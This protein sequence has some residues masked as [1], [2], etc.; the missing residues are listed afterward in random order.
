MKYYQNNLITGLKIA[1]WTRVGIIALS[2]FITIYILITS[3]KRYTAAIE[4]TYVFSSNGAAIEVN[5]KK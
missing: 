5:T 3:Y 4:S 2:G 1:I